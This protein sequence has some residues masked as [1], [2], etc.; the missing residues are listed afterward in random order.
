M[1]RSLL[2][3]GLLLWMGAVLAQVAEFRDFRLVRIDDP[4]QV[5][6]TSA[7]DPSALKRAIT[8]AAAG[9]DWQVA[10]DSQGQ[11]ELTRT[12][13]NKHSMRVALILQPRGYSIRYLSSANLLYDEKAV[14]TRGNTHRAIHKN[15]NVWIR[16]LAA[17][18]NTATGT[19]GAAAVTAAHSATPASASRGPGLPAQVPEGVSIV[20]P[21]AGAAPQAAMYSGQWSGT[22]GSTLPHILVIERVD[23]RNVAA[24]YCWGTNQSTP[25]AGCTRNTGL[26]GEDGVLRIALRAGAEVTYRVNADGRSLRGEYLRNSRITFGT[27][28]KVVR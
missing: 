14:N 19:T 15:Y 10:T 6:F 22:W 21:G 8:A 18:I 28:D 4:L 25:D 17:A 23:G 26:V 3:C 11:L 24:L 9:K 13:S 16:E 2:A 1:K 12:V 20:A 5:E 7:I 27:F